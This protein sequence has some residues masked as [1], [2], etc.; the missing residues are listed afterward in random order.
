[1]RHAL[2]AMRYALCAMRF[3]IKS[4]IRNPKSNES[5]I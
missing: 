1:M 3:A 5:E 2:C 4:E